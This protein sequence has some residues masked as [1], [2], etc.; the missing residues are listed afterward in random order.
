MDTGKQL[1]S[2]Q[3]AFLGVEA[4]RRELGIQLRASVF[5]LHT[6]REDVNHCR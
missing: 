1:P 2:A 3:D 5:A 6:R 4:E